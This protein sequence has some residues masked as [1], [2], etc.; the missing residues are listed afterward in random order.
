MLTI[1]QWLNYQTVRS[2]WTVAAKP[3]AGPKEA[4]FSE[5]QTRLARLNRSQAASNT[6][7]QTG[8]ALKSFLLSQHELAGQEYLPAS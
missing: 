4:S 3:Q 6:R 7:L 8:R 1:S 5:T 2:N